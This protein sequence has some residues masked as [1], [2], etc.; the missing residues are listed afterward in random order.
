[1]NAFPSHALRPLQHRLGIGQL[2]AVPVPFQDSPAALDGVVLA[3]VRRIL[4]HKQLQFILYE[5]SPD[6]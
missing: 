1:M 3:V 5:R 4:S 6:A 2:G